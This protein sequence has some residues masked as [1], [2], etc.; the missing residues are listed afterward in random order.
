MVFGAAGVT[1]VTGGQNY[2]SDI[3]P[4][5]WQAPYAN[6]AK[7]NNVIGGYSDGTFKPNNPITR[8]EAFKIIINTFHPDALDTVSFAVFSDVSL[9]QWY[10]PYANFAKSNELIHFTGNAFEPDTLMNRGEVANAIYVLMN[11]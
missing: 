8:A 2:F 11:M 1:L 4:N 5:S 6:T 3:D 9:D 7:I 10:A